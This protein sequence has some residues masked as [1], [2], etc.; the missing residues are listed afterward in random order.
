M[1][2]AH[3][4]V[5]PSTAGSGFPDQLLRMRVA[6]TK[7]TDRGRMGLMTTESSK[8]FGFDDGDILCIAWVDLNTV[9]YMTT[10]IQ[11]MK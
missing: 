5:H 9:Q 7:Q 6:A 8:K 4:P 1:D 11:L 3:H 2:H 10:V